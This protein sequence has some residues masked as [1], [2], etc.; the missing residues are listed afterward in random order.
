VA[1]PERW[2]KVEQLLDQAL[3]L[4]P[5][6]RAAFLDRSCCGDAALR[7]EVERLLAASEGAASFLE[8]PGPAYAAP[9]VSRVQGTPGS[10]QRLGPYEI[11]RELGRG[12]MATVYLARDLKH[13]RPVALKLLHAELAA[14]LGP[15]RFL[16]EIR[17]T[18]RL[19]HPHILTVLDSG[20]AAGLLWYTMPYVE[21]EALRDGYGVRASSP[22]TMSCASPA[23]WA[24]AAK[25]RRSWLCGPLRCRESMGSRCSVGGACRFFERRTRPPTSWRMWERAVRTRPNTDA[26]VG[27]MG[28]GAIEGATCVRT[29]VQ[30]PDYCRLHRTTRLSPKCRKHNTC[31]V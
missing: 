17:Q 2:Q 26:G 25:V 15:E 1:S 29:C 18:A 24:P 20:N 27:A 14:A 31:T 5:A 28:W 12:G 13:E 8:E 3:E 7:A 9:L 22:W 10:G 11:V 19:Q 6:D 21:G 4:A 23:R 30:T 16:R